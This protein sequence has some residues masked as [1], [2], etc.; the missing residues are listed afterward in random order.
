MPKPHIRYKTRAKAKAVVPIHPTSVWLPE[1]LRQ[2]LQEEAD[3]LRRSR[4]WVIIEVLR[5]WQSFWRAKKKHKQQ[6]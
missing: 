4:S 3:K 5:Q 6:D 1:D 2:D